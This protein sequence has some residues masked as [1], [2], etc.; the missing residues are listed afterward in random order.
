MA[1]NYTTYT[2]VDPNNK[3]SVSPT[4]ITFSGLQRNV[5]AYVYKDFGTDYFSGDFTHL[6]DI[7]ITG[8]SSEIGSC[9]PWML[10]NGVDDEKG[11]RDASQ[12]YIFCQLS[13]GGS[14]TLIL[15][16][17]YNGTFYDHTYGF[18]NL[19]TTYYLKIVRDE[20]VG[21]YGTLYCYIYT[22]VNRTSLLTTL[23]VT[24]HAKLD[25]R[26]LYGLNSLNNGDSNILSGAVSNLD[27]GF[28]N[29]NTTDTGTGT[30]AVSVNFGTSTITITDTG[31]GTD[32][33]SVNVGA[34]TITITDT[35]TGADD[36]TS[37]TASLTITDTGNGL[38]AIL[39]YNG[40]L[41]S[42]TETGGGVDTLTS[43]LAALGIS[44]TASGADG[45]NVS[46]GSSSTIIL[47][48]T[49][50]WP[51]GQTA[52]YQIVDEFQAV[53]Q[54]WTS[55][56]VFEIQNMKKSAYHVK[57]SPL[58][59]YTIF[60]KI[61]GTRYEAH[62]TVDLFESNND[63][64]TST[65]L[66][67]ADYTAPDNAGI[68]QIQADIATAQADIT[69]ILNYAIAMSKWKNNKMVKTGTVGATETWVIYDD[70]NT[71]PLLT[72]TFNTSTKVRTKAT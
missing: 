46:G 70:D 30:D 19:S 5:D 36:V 4:S 31:T 47:E 17:R 28:S 26:Y 56:G 29:I 68:T 40:Q 35:G 65:R 22:D 62:R 61:A 50:P 43:I 57:I 37:L 53:V 52:Q 11:L 24:L 27:T 6:I 12:N 55:A 38:D 41:V 13:G 34:S 51:Q 58:A 16:E 2:E 33:V 72:Y 7:S 60:W 25:F 14:G 23:S 10:A 15:R 32:A 69:S 64:A 48:S 71:T 18:L 44:D 8:P 21:T 3:I 42:V 20:A 63:I 59:Q 1:E 49:P 39:A 67:A 66:A 45:I 54:A 9:E